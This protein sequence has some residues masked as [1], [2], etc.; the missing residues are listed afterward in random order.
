MSAF[1]L[2]LLTLRRNLFY[3]LFVAS[4]V[5]FLLYVADGFVQYSRHVRLERQS[6]RTVDA[7]VIAPKGSSVEHLRRLLK[8]ELF[9]EPALIPSQ[10]YTTLNTDPP[11][12]LK[13]TPVLFWGSYKKIPVI[14]ADLKLQE[15]LISSFPELEH[16]T[17]AT[18]DRKAVADRYH[19]DAGDHIDVKSA[20]GH[21]ALN[22][23]Q[24]SFMIK[25]I[26]DLGAWDGAI[27][28]S[29]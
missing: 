20:F 28:S 15:I 8:L 9:A 1:R 26:A 5:A 24:D 25:G 18:F 10:L 3:A 2:A 19:L 14:A 6:L 12:G 16:S 27:L 13:L 29:G 22:T 7:D 21:L 17:N 4:G 11:P 23:F